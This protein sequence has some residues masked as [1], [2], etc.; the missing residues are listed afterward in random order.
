M[1]QLLEFCQR[2][3][4]VQLRF[5][6]YDI[7]YPQL[8]QKRLI[9]IAGL[10]GEHL[11]HMGRGIHIMQGRAFPAQLSMGVHRHIEHAELRLRQIIPRR[12]GGRGL[13]QHRLLVKGK[14][15]VCG[16]SAGQPAL[17]MIKGLLPKG[18]VIEYIPCG[19]ALGCAHVFTHD[20]AV[21]RGHHV[22]ENIWSVHSLH[23]FKIS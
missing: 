1:E 6:R 5:S 4:I 11:D 15:V 23:S 10:T 17:M 8:P 21:Q 9:R 12:Y 14:I 13:I 16:H 20:L 2:Q 22:A 7:G 19:T 18:N 3:G